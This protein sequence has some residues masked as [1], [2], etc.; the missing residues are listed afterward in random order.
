MTNSFIKYAF[1]SGELSP[2]LFGRSDLEKYDLGME[3]ISDWIVDYRGGLSTR[4]GFELCGEALYPNTRSKFFKF[5]FGPQLSNTY[6]VIFEENTIKFIQ[7]GGYVLEAAKVVTGLTQAAT[8]VVG[9]AAHGYASNDLIYL[10]DIVGMTEV[11]DRLFRV[12]TVT[13]NT[14]TLLRP[15]GDPIDTTG[16]GAFVSGGTAQRVY[17]V[18]HPYIVEELRTLRAFQVRDT[19][20]LT[21]DDYR[22]RNLTRIDHTNWTLDIEE[23]GNDLVQP[24][25][26]LIT[27]SAAGVASVGYQVTAVDTDGMESL[28]SDMAIDS[29]C[30]NFT[31]TAGSVTLTW[32]AVPGTKFY[33]VYRTL[34]LPGPDDGTSAAPVVSK[35]EQ[36]GFVGQSYAPRFVDA[37]IIPDFTVAPPLQTNPFANSAILSVDVTAGGTGYSVTDTLTAIGDG[38]TGTGFDG[39]PIVDASGVIVGV[40]VTRGGKNYDDPVVITAS[41]GTGA[42]FDVTTTSPVSNDPRVSAIFQQRQVYASSENFPLTIWAS[43]PGTFNNFDVSQVTADDDSLDLEI[44]SAQ[45]AEIQHLVVSRGGLLALSQYGIWQLHGD[46]QGAGPLTPSNAIADPQNYRGCSSVPPLVIDTDLLHIEGKG[47]T[48]RL[49][50]YNDITKVYSGTDVSILSNHLFTPDNQILAW[51]HA[52]NPYQVVWACRTDGSLVT[53][54]MVKEQQ[55]FAWAPAYTRGL[56]TDVCT[57]L[58]NGT[59]STYLAVRRF[60]NGEWMK[61]FERVHSREFKY[62]EDAFCV[63]CGLSTSHTYPA[64]TLTIEAAEGEDVLFTTDA[65]VFVSGDVGSVIRAGGG[66]AYITEFIGTESVRATLERPVTKVVFHDAANTPLPAAS[67]TWTLDAPF[68][69]VSGLWHLIG[70]EVQIL[71]DGNVRPPQVVAADGSVSLGVEGTQAH[72][73]LKFRPIARTLPLAAQGTPIENKRKRVVEIAARVDRTRGLSYGPTLDE[74]HEVAERSDE[75]YNAPT[76]LQN[77]I[78]FQ[79][80][81]DGFNDT[82]QVYLVQE[83]PLPSTVV[84]LVLDVE[85][86]DSNRDQG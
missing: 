42:T 41:G 67:G 47:L 13:S 52:P 79:L 81:N 39:F 37:N 75:D 77:G 3:K 46:Q 32:T 1:V 50:G 58:E 2:T 78:Q 51:D 8:G 21:R 64:A 15:N 74:L 84:G 45:V 25:G 66:L 71:L 5:L 54:T 19:L 22:V 73:G 86:G 28:P 4:P 62:E 61:F 16:Y 9:L 34:V 24:T 43:I 69:T 14:F 65:P 48:V 76:R 59:D 23:F 26:L 27:P 53:F 29:A 63:D 17:Q 30:V 55:V 36:V 40:Y 11:N 33:N 49:L 57:I 44:D 35:A 85:V 38:A 83:N 6:L 60:I 12:G 82:G 18:P 70:E 72:I 80:L 68:D 31:S 20:R 56:V 7:D 10:F